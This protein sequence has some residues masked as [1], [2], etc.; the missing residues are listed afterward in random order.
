MHDYYVTVEGGAT[1]NVEAI[2]CTDGAGNPLTAAQLAI[3]PTS[4]AANASVGNWLGVQIG[5][6][7]AYTPICTSHNINNV[8]IANGPANSP[9][10][11]KD[12]PTVAVL[13]GGQKIS[14]DFKVFRLLPAPDF[15]RHQHRYQLLGSGLCLV[16]AR[17]ELRSWL[18]PGRRH[19]GPVHGLRHRP[20]FVHQSVS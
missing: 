19:H 16:H 12:E 5:G 7:G 20:R 10:I 9:T 6:S 13:G 4:N 17:Q 8:G 1:I 14:L 2:N 18:L 15:Q 11:I 3:T